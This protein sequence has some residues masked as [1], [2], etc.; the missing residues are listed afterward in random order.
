M[1]QEIQLHGSSLHPDPGQWSHEDFVA[2]WQANDNHATWNKALLA[3]AYEAAGHGDL[4]RYADAV[5]VA[6]STMKGYRSV[7]RAYAK[8]SD[9]RTFP[10]GV[11]ETL[12]GQEDR[13]E[14]VSRSEPWT[15]AEARELVARRKA[16]KALV[17]SGPH[18]DI[19]QELD[20]GKPGKP[21]GPPPEQVAGAVPATAETVTT[22]TEPGPEPHAHVFACS[23]GKTDTAF[24]E[25]AGQLM[26][27]LEE[28]RKNA[29][30][31]DPAWHQQAE[32]LLKQ[33]ADKGWA[34]D[35]AKFAKPPPAVAGEHA[36]H[37]V[38]SNK[39]ARWFCET[40]REWF[41]RAAA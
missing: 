30:G 31:H 38:V 12:M 13:F 4:K 16:G 20:R 15:V 17:R 3:A 40:C 19:R 5:G 41:D 23:C 14:L 10:F 34:W 37:R 29:C 36:G 2:A 25:Q 8:G 27:E 24:S 6:Y 32:W 11:A 28:A 26:E 35:G 33:M 1:A 22:A 39:G 21:P 7:A 9:V 18:K